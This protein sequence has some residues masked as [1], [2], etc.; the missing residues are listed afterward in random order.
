[1]APPVLFGQPG[2]KVSLKR[3]LLTFFFVASALSAAPILRLSSATVGPVPASGGTNA[4]TQTIYASNLGD[5]NLNLTASASDAWLSAQVGSNGPCA[6][7]SGNCIPI[8]IAL[9]TAAVANGT[10]TGFVTI[11]DPNAVDSPQTV[12]V[13]VQ[14]GGVPAAIDLYAAPN[15]GTATATFETRSAV[16]ANA[17]TQTGGNWLSVALDGAGSFGF[18]Y[19]YVITA[20]T[21]P[22]QAAGDYQGAVQFSGSTYAPD[23]R[24]VGVTLHVTSAPILQLTDTPLRL[25][26]VQGSAAATGVVTLQNT[27]QGTAAI[28]GASSTSS[29]LSATVTDNSH[30]TVTAT[31]GSLAPGTYSGTV[32]VASNAANPVSIPVTFVVRATSAPVASLGGV[33]EN[34]VGTG[35]LAPGD[36]ASVYGDQFVASSATPA[37]SLPLPT[38]LGGTQVLFN[39]TPAPL[40][41]TSAGQINF[42]VPY[43]AQPGLATV[44]VVR[45][46]QAG[47]LV[48]ATV[49]S[50]APRILRFQPPYG[51][52]PI[53]VNQDGSIPVTGSAPLPSH[54]A[55]PGDYLVIYM[56]GLG[57]TS[58]AVVAGA[59]A[60][61]AEPLARVDA[62]VT[63]ILGGGFMPSVMPTVLY[64]G[65]TPGFAGLYQIN[66][67]IPADASGGSSV[68]LSVTV[69]GG[70]TNVVNI[71]ITR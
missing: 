48:S 21:Q 3:N 13:T 4:A 50:H 51:T 31:P 22:G 36:I 39:S 52:V 17:T 66:I 25:S 12:S 24:S 20:A 23:N 11:S 53:I 10:Y 67:Q 7:G 43:D 65:L 40:Y 41:Y 54:P 59:A 71:A 64:A 33:V 6:T 62:P 46:G 32:T 37:S 19:P 29:F 68:P 16:T 38:I 1:M 8:Q 2:E 28:T 34:A 14:V 27:G 49:V 56:I 57:T 42:Q 45:G 61:G 47:N 63:V 70:G 55:K 58:P 60:P 69:D 44:Q 35:T 5:G 15:G 9:N 18:F 26:A 30:V